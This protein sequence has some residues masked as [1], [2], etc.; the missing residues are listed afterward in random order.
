[1]FEHVSTGALEY[2]EA[3]LY[4]GMAERGEYRRVCDAMA[5]GLVERWYD[6]GNAGGLMGLAKTRL[7]EAGRAELSGRRAGE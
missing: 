3:G 1:M 7:T 6:H 5:A 4:L 2:A